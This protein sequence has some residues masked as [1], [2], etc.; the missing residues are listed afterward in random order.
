MKQIPPHLRR[1]LRQILVSLYDD[2]ETIRLLVDDAEIR[3][4]L[5]DFNCSP[6]VLWGKV[7]K[8]A[9]KNRKLSS[10]LDMAFHDYPR[11]ERLKEAAERYYKFVGESLGK[12]EDRWREEDL[13]SAEPSQSGPDD[14][15]VQSQI[16][17]YLDKVSASLQ[18]ELIQG[19]CRSLGLSENGI[20]EQLSELGPTLETI[21]SIRVQNNS[22][23]DDDTRSSILDLLL[24]DHSK[25]VLTGEPGIGKSHILQSIALY[26]VQQRYDKE[27]AEF[28]PIY[29]PLEKITSDNT[30][31]TLIRR[32]L[33]RFGLAI[34]NTDLDM[35][36]STEKILFLID[37]LNFISSNHDIY[38]ETLTNIGILTESSHCKF[39]VTDR[40]SYDKALNRYGFSTYEV[41]KWDLEKISDYISLALG[42]LGSTNSAQVLLK[43][44]K[45]DHALYQIVSNPFMLGLLVT[46][47]SEDNEVMSQRTS[48][49]H[50][51]IQKL[52]NEINPNSYGRSLGAK[53][54]Q[55]LLSE[56]AFASYQAM[57]PQLTEEF[58]ITSLEQKL[59][60]RYSQ[61]QMHQ[62]DAP[63]ALESLLQD[64]WLRKVDNHYR[65]QS[66]LFQ[67]MFL[68]YMVQNRRKE[69]QSVD[70][71]IRDPRAESAII[72]AA[73]LLSGKSAD[74]LV[75]RVSKLGDIM[76]AARCAIGLTTDSSIRRTIASQLSRKLYSNID[77]ERIEASDLLIFLADHQAIT[78][79]RHML[80]KGSGIAQS[81]S[82][83]AIQRILDRGDDVGYD[84]E[85]I[86]PSDEEFIH[87]LENPHYSE[88]AHTTACD[89]LSRSKTQRAVNELI[90]TLSS[91]YRK[92][93]SKAADGLGQINEPQV[94][95]LLQ[96]A[97]HEDDS[98]EIKAGALRALHSAQPQL[99][100]S[101]AQGMKH[102]ASSHIQTEIELV[103]GKHGDAP[104]IDQ[105]IQHARSGQT[106]RQKQAIRFC[107]EVK[108]AHFID[109]LWDLLHRGAPDLQEDVARALGGIR[110]ERVM[111]RAMTDS[112]HNDEGI[113]EAALKVL[114]NI[115][116]DEVV[117]DFLIMALSDAG[118]MVRNTAVRGLI[119]FGERA[120]PRLDQALEEASVDGHL[121]LVC[122]I[123]SVYEKVGT[124]HAIQVLASGL[125]SPLQQVRQQAMTSLEN[126]NREIAILTLR[127]KWQTIASDQQRPIHQ[128]LH[129]LES[130]YHYQL[131]ISYDLQTVDG[132]SASYHILDRIRQDAHSDIPATRASAEKV[133]NLIEDAQAPFLPLPALR[134]GLQTQDPKIKIRIIRDAIEMG[135]SQAIE[136]LEPVISDGSREVRLSLARSLARATCPEAV[137]I[138]KQMVMG[139]QDKEIR[140]TALTALKRTAEQSAIR[141]LI[142]LF[143]QRKILQGEILNNL[144]GHPGLRQNRAGIRALLDLAISGNRQL[145]NQV[146]H[147]I[148]K[149]RPEHLPSDY[150]EIFV[151]SLITQKRNRKQILDLLVQVVQKEIR[152]NPEHNRSV[153]RQ[154]VPHLGK[155]KALDH[156]I[157]IVLSDLPVDT[158][159]AVLAQHLSAANP[160][161]IS[162]TLRILAVIGPSKVLPEVQNLLDQSVAD[163]RVQ[164]AKVL[165]NTKSEDVIPALVDCL[166]DSDQRIQKHAVYG[167]LNHCNAISVVN[168]LT[169]FLKETTDDNLRCEVTIGLGQVNPA[170]TIDVLLWLIDHDHFESREVAS[171]LLRRH[172]SPE[173]DSK[174]LRL[175]NAPAAQI[176][177]TIVR[178][179]G[180]LQLSATA[181][182]LQELTA[183]PHD[184]TIRQAAALSLLEIGLKSGDI[185]LAEVEATLRSIFADL[186]KALVAQNAETRANAIS[187]LR[188][189]HADILT[190]YVAAA[191]DDEDV[192]VCM[193]ALNTLS[194]FSSRE[195]V[196]H[197]GRA[198]LHQ[199]GKIRERAFV[200][201]TKFLSHTDFVREATQGICYLI[202][203]SK[204]ELRR[205]AIRT[206][207][208]FENKIS[209]KALISVIHEGDEDLRVEIVQALAQREWY[210][211][212]DRLRQAKMDP[213]HRVRQVAEE[214][215]AQME[216]ILC[217]R[218][219]KAAE[220]IRQGTSHFFNPIANQEIRSL[221]SALGPEA[222]TRMILQRNKN[223]RTK[224]YFTLTAADLIVL[225]WLGHASGYEAILSSLWVPEKHSR[226]NKDERTGK[227]K[228]IAG[229][230]AAGNARI[231][232]AL[233][234]L[235][236][237]MRSADI[238][239]KQAAIYAVAKIAPA[240]IDKAAPLLYQHPNQ[241]V[242]FAILISLGAIKSKE[243]MQLVENALQDHA[244]AVREA[245]IHILETS[246]VQGS[247]HCL[248][249]QLESEPMPKLR[250][251]ILQVF[252]RAESLHLQEVIAELTLDKDP[253]IVI[254]AM[255]LCAQFDITDS[256]PYLRQQYESNSNQSI[257]Q[258]VLASLLSM[259][260]LQAEDALYDILRP[261]MQTTIWDNMTQT[262]KL[263]GTTKAQET[264]PTEF[265]LCNENRDL[266]IEILN[267]AKQLPTLS[268]F[269]KKFITALIRN[270]QE[271]IRIQ[272]IR[273]ISKHKN[274]EWLSLLYEC[275]K[276]KSVDVRLKAFDVLKGWDGVTSSDSLQSVCIREANYLAKRKFLTHFCTPE[277]QAFL[278]SEGQ[279]EDFIRQLLVTESRQEL[280]KNLVTGK[281]IST[282]PQKYLKRA[283]PTPIQLQAIKEIGSRHLN[284]YR[285]KI[286]RY[287][288]HPV[289]PLKIAAMDALAELAD[290]D[291]EYKTI[292][293]M[294]EDP[295]WVVSFKAI[296]TLG[297][298]REVRA[299]THLGQWILPADTRSE[300]ATSNNNTGSRSVGQ[301]TVIRSKQY[302]VSQALIRIASVEAKELISNLL[303]TAEN[304]K[305]VT[306]LLH[307]M[308][309]WQDVNWAT[310]L[311]RGFENP[312]QRIRQI[313][314]SNLSGFPVSNIE[315]TVRK[316]INSPSIPIAGDAIDM[317]G[318][319]QI[320]ALISELRFMLTLDPYTESYKLAQAIRALGR[321]RA[322]DLS[323]DL[324]KLLGSPL[325][326]VAEAS[327]NA[328]GQL[329]DVAGIRFLHSALQREENGRVEL[330]AI[331]SLAKIGTDAACIGMSYIQSQLLDQIRDSAIHSLR[332]YSHTEAI[333][334]LSEMLNDENH[335]IR[336]NVVKVLSLFADFGTLP[337]LIKTAKEDDNMFVRIAAIEGLEKAEG[338]E[339]VAA[340]K[341]SSFLFDLL[342]DPIGKV[343]TRA[344]VLVSQIAPGMY[345]S[346]LVELLYEDNAH[347]REAAIAALSAHPN[348]IW[349]GAVAELTRFDSSSTIRQ[350]AL[351]A[352]EEAH[353]DESHQVVQ[354]LREERAY[355]NQKLQSR[356]LSSLYS[357]LKRYAWDGSHVE[358]ETEKESFLI[359]IETAMGEDVP[360]LRIQAGQ[361]ASQISFPELIPC[362]VQA[363]TD[364]SPKVRSYA[365]CALANIDDPKA[366]KQLGGFLA[367]ETE[368]IV[369]FQLLQYLSDNVQESTVVPILRQALLGPNHRLGKYAVA[370]L[371]NVPHPEAVVVLQEALRQPHP[372]PFVREA[373]VKALA[374]KEAAEAIED[375]KDAVNDPVWY[376]SRD[377][378]TA[379]ASL[380]DSSTV[381]EVCERGLAN[382]NAYVRRSAVK[383]LATQKSVAAL[384]L[385][386]KGL[387]DNTS[388]IRIH[389]L[390]GIQVLHENQIEGTN[391]A[392]EKVWSRTA[393]TLLRMYGDE[394]DEGVKL[395]WIETFQQLKP[396]FLPQFVETNLLNPNTAIRRAMLELADTCKEK[397]S[398]S[399]IEKQYLS[400]V[401]Q[402]S[403][404][405]RRDISFY[406]RDMS[407][408][409]IQLLWNC[410]RDPDYLVR[411]NA[412]FGLR[413]IPEKQPVEQLRRLCRDHDTLVRRIAWQSL[414]KITL[415]YPELSAAVD[416]HLRQSWHNSDKQRS[417]D[418]IYREMVKQ[419][420][421]KN[422]IERAY[423]IQSLADHPRQ[424]TISFLID[425]YLEEKV[426]S[427]QQVIVEV[428]EE[429]NKELAISTIM[430]MGQSKDKKL[431]ELRTK[432][433]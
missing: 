375:L 403:I 415:Q 225:G 230:G 183:R 89:A 8:E 93:R 50:Q 353:T 337:L 262:L 358:T 344:I 151:E 24:N 295:N 238:H 6:D 12:G 396:P 123:L 398:F 106:S 293:R 110:D 172:Y 75:E 280:Q 170:Q 384:P 18:D 30:L 167:L 326:P 134:E 72:H 149:I 286:I 64:N 343:K 265:P 277:N 28:I 239:E 136:L 404:S 117:M 126:T 395:A 354:R 348:P 409:C 327:A 197:M 296:E 130:E 176:K 155:S 78:D 227:N 281:Y 182:K 349:Y 325:W 175:L 323:A 95:A 297:K 304:P 153:S 254:S 433:A 342:N 393:D 181:A 324:K 205:S 142:D 186:P 233:P 351:T 76:Q 287:L 193:K 360:V 43:R 34:Q 185:N 187:E 17:I 365:L 27:I 390:R 98:L 250:N 206:L 418:D 270:E 367:K 124:R 386:M 320:H 260:A 74:Q 357:R 152:V 412:A 202:Y 300:R 402:A 248:L 242:R 41:A 339:K 157:Q 315:S 321:L 37:G 160:A 309:K 362:L 317:I 70:L 210:H 36:I 429:M 215:V 180:Q 201:L 330:A 387:K 352:L 263:F 240:E 5:I 388:F 87:I 276:D 92:V 338:L 422:L 283:L 328:F 14:S 140:S 241:Y 247:I 179:V 341:D 146:G 32:E 334:S 20:S 58:V 19:T 115:K 108:S 218:L 425:S 47:Y 261:K 137:E 298:V 336:E 159:Q 209:T 161:A 381:I 65:F 316:A 99:A 347:V 319:L 235:L 310:V 213:A 350:M 220:K 273:V 46:I 313:L 39:V 67:E 94:I 299:V 373:I 243:N 23:P 102:Q 289:P 380:A 253:N 194:A 1:N 379:V 361:A 80:I 156:A 52:L 269:A 237:F 214:A 113:R 282:N 122:I 308:Q 431:A 374:C 301:N 251:R 368:T 256:I 2:K 414:E 290:L 154:L 311:K 211:T 195:A 245:A 38:R 3:A 221:V 271:E 62:V 56:L 217:Q 148:R 364:P 333:D 222:G 135:T 345:Q 307:T 114:G 199:D 356:E 258:Q 125:D 291:E 208:E 192:H 303:L 419:A 363:A 31:R 105:Y 392:K 165:G 162:S 81:N 145:W 216:E 109:P 91:P 33:N 408:E 158:T 121:D 100:L 302:I 171:Q 329:Q 432:L 203:D 411:T 417:K 112:R 369:Q 371:K 406:V 401:K 97:I 188:Y 86:R 83:L 382:A 279:T 35:F 420:K 174:L 85:G 413:H 359:D 71:F 48:L 428:L 397:I 13:A 322:E 16:E 51:F 228:R 139:D 133:L 318:V 116:N 314:V 143:W 164:A 22:E 377:A 147:I 278:Q 207:M 9:E 68:A 184:K 257:R 61:N 200:H 29:I 163:V 223:R 141:A 90:R 77:R 284:Q 107:L 426:A 73:G 332:F 63:A 66:D 111:N 430:D 292:L 340:I 4:S 54:T 191:L 144:E 150:K 407:Q 305:F 26:V 198:T 212:L 129:K 410:S 84:T 229:I 236:T 394:R 96:Q 69:N 252:T 232:V 168:H 306:H 421:S 427:V 285:N 15:R 82:A 244:Y 55:I 370:A 59:N 259:H 423:A 272:A 42:L 234:D 275:L 378:I 204:L 178:L 25:V 10:L 101:M 385:L 231:Q 60:E 169:N 376:V 312:D 127:E 391:D 79:L 331:W 49:I 132:R 267:V 249:M 120:A 7:I 400:R 226:D 173:L 44:I 268:P 40:P 274:S 166:Q 366:T 119:K 389:S 224:G 405:E 189:I 196:C 118:S 246:G 53:N 255:Q 335:F 219:R 190:P 21:Q 104:T 399:A 103:L 372:G 424:K 45:Q 138:L 11:N 131:L 266:Y 416:E 294:I 57:T 88:D 264:E 355:Q 346:E 177:P 128:L 383:A 288:N